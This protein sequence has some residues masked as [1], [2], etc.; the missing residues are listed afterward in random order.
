MANYLL[1]RRNGKQ[2]AIDVLQSSNKPTPDRFDMVA[3]GSYDWQKDATSFVILPDPELPPCITD[4]LNPYRYI[5][6]LGIVKEFED[7]VFD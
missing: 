7:I 5:V 1:Q 2:I 6:R 4:L 3:I